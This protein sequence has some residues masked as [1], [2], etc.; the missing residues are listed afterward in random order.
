[1]EDF[2]QDD[3][4]SPR[5]HAVDLSLR[6]PWGPWDGRS[7]S[8]DPLLPCRQQQCGLPPGRGGLFNRDHNQASSST[9]VPG[10]RPPS[11]RTPRKG[12]LSSPAQNGEEEQSGQGNEFDRRGFRE[13]WAPPVR[14]GEGDA[15]GSKPAP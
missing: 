7:D 3:T 11:L 8:Y 10:Q 6:S 5:A 13:E 12:T 4:G 1:M 2:P 15:T 14:V 9:N